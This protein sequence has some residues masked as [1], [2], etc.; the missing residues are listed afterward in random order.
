MVACVAGAS[1]I[2][3]PSKLVVAGMVVSLRTS[4]KNLCGFNC[5]EIGDLWCDCPVLCVVCRRRGHIQSDCCKAMQGNGPAG[6]AVL[7][8][9]APAFQH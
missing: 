1:S 5:N 3:N 7:N 9:A 4:L 2:K 6:V 8:Q